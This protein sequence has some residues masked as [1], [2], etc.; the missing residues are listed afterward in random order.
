MPVGVFPWLQQLSND[1]ETS[2]VRS[3]PLGAVRS[4]F[5]NAGK[6]Q[7]EWDN[8]T[9]AGNGYRVNRSTGSFDWRM[10]DFNVPILAICFWSTI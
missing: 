2:A 8:L 7:P 1:T 6:R 9:S 10:I 3:N 5:R 4:T